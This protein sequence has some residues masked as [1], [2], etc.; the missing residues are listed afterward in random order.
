MIIFYNLKK[1][2]E[3]V[4]NIEGR[5]HNEAQLK[6]TMG[7]TGVDPKDIGKIV[8][9]WK[10]AKQWVENG[11]KFF[12]FEPDHVQKDIFRILDK[13]STDVYKYKVDLKTKNLVLK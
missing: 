13:S 3:I 5:I 1:D 12:E 11:R 9:Q 7:I 8:C 10:I 4:G 2:G 6:V